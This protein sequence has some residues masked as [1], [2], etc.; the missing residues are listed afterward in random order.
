MQASMGKGLYPWR[1]VLR[2]VPFASETLMRNN[3]LLVGN[4]EPSRPVDRSLT[5]D[6]DLVV[7]FNRCRSIQA[8]DRIDIL[9]IVDKADP[10]AHVFDSK[11]RIWIPNLTPF[12]DTGK[13]PEE[14]K[15]VM[16]R[17]VPKYRPSEIRFI[18]YNPG[19]VYKGKGPS[20]GFTILNY[21]LTTPE[22]DNYKV[23]M[24][25]FG[26]VGSDWHDWEFER[27]YCQH[28]NDRGTITII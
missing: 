15:E 13:L 21:L 20:S 25:G 3:I 2:E 19:P 24:I 6:Y 27:S 22:F 12:D 23:S 26:W 1:L 8:G 11:P 17:I 4:G 7:R 14:T 9:S 5:K 18:A 10:P 16:Y 28:L